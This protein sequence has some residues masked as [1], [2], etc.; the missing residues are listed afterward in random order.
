M[1]SFTSVPAY[2]LLKLCSYDEQP[3][4]VVHVVLAWHQALLSLPLLGRVDL[5]VPDLG[6]R[7]LVLL[8]I[9]PAPEEHSPRLIV[10]DGVDGP[11]CRTGR[12]LP[13]DLTCSFEQAPMV[14]AEARQH[15]LAVASV[16]LAAGH[17]RRSL[18]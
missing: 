3:L 6:S 1:N 11:G 18:N 16:I 10:F 12:E 7:R 5:A 2:L 13:V 4:V 9:K 17:E 8:S 14:A 15:L